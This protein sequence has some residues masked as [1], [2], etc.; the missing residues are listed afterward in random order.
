M[1]CA[2]KCDRCGKYYDKSTLDKG[3]RLYKN[4]NTTVLDLCEECKASLTDWL[5]HEEYIEQFIKHRSFKFL[6]DG[7][8]SYITL[9]HFIEAL[10]RYFDYDWTNPNMEKFIKDRT[11][12]KD[13]GGPHWHNNQEII[14]TRTAKECLINYLD[15]E[16]K[17]EIYDKY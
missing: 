10:E 11:C 1:A 13:L 14:M 8:I 2:F 15:Y 3:P 16:W 12:T 7:L 17:D 5:N 6:D 4:K 9:A